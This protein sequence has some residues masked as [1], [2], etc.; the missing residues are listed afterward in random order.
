MEATK[1]ATYT[2]RQEMVAE[3]LAL[4]HRDL[5]WYKSYFVSASASRDGRFL[6]VCMINDLSKPPE[7]RDWMVRYDREEGRILCIWREDAMLIGGMS[8]GLK[9]VISIPNEII[10]TP[11]D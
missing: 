3:V 7:E 4:F 5:A 1:P 6:D 10:E 8:T 11:E 9:Q 2:Q